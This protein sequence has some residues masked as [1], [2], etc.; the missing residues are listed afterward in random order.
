MLKLNREALI[1]VNGKLA[2]VL[3]EYKEGK[4][5]RIVFQYEDSYLKSGSPIGSPFPLSPLPF[6]W[7]ELPNFFHNLASEGWLRKVQCKRD[8]LENEDTLGLL[9]KNGKELIGALSIV[10]HNL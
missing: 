5:E 3:S 1:L 2:G 6:E 4:K 8:S 7:D 10:Q 9:L